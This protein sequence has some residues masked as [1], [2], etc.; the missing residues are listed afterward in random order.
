[1]TNGANT[2]A[3]ELGLLE[4]E[5]FE[6]DE[7]R[8]LKAAIALTLVW[9]CTAVLHLLTWGQWVVYG[10]TLLTGAHLFRLLLAPVDALPAPLPSWCEGDNPDTGEPEGSGWPYVSILVAAKNERAVIKRLVADLTALDYPP[11][12]YDV[13]LIDDNS[14]DGTAEL[15]DAVAAQFPNVQIVRRDHTATGGKSGALNQVWRKTKGS[16][17]VVFDADAQ[18]S[19]DCLRRVVPM[20]DQPS[21]GAVQMRKAIANGNHNFWTRSQVAEMAFDAYCQLKRTTRAGIGELRGNGQFVRRSALEQCGGWNEETITDDLD[22]TFRLHLT[23]WDIPLVMFPAVWEDGVV[24]PVALWHQRNRWAEGGYQRYLDYWRWLT[25]TRLGW[26]KAFDLFVFWL[27]QYA[28]P[29]AALPDFALAV[30]RNRL[31]VMLPL[32]SLVVLFSTLGMARGLRQTRKASIFSIF[33]QTLR[34]MVYMMHWILVVGTVTLRMAIR[35]KRLKWVKTQ[36][37]ELDEQ[38]VSSF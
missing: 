4:A 9:S 8:R 24:Q 6:S 7:R 15:L 29:T 14:T 34:G 37:G 32:S 25:P 12:R 5:L 17:L 13:W 2:E 18:L 11:H 33:V 36:H 26:G 20:F 28:L 10:L 30:A 22:L 31:P 1:M 16:L 35:P 3:I 19:P 38:S 21:V 23:G 27:I